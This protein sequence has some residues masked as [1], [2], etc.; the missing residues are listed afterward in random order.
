MRPEKAGLFHGTKV[1]FLEAY[2]H[3]ESWG[4]DYVK[5][6]DTGTFSVGVAWRGEFRPDDSAVTLTL[7][8]VARAEEA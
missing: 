8:P 1:E 6:T 2:E 7:V 4:V 5:G 3:P